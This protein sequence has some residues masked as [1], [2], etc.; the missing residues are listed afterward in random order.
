MNPIVRVEH[1]EKRF[2]RVAAIEGVSFE[3]PIG[4]TL[5]LLG[6]NGSGKTTLLRLLAGV[7]RPTRGTVRVFDAD[8]YRDPHR[9]ARRMGISYENHFLSPWATARDYLRFAAKAQGLDNGAVHEAGHD[10]ELMDYWDRDM[11]T[12]S[13]GMSKR[14][15]LAQAWLGNPGLLLLDEP[16]STL[17][18]QGRSILADLLSARSAA[19]QT[20][21]VATHLAE[22]VTLP[23]HVACLLLG[24]LEAEG[25]VSEL[26]V[27][28]GARSVA[29]ALPDPPEGVRALLEAGISSVTAT[30]DRVIVKGDQDT[31]GR[32]GEILRG[33][34][35]SAEPVEETFD[36]W[37]IYRSVLEGHDR[38]DL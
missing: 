32:A 13:A 6:P 34:G 33:M 8:P 28:Y 24:H 35:A 30:R 20:T 25:T 37:A 16:F 31:V 38:S 7:L 18:P 5:F 17:D 21:L 23:T 10:W 26:A 9:L 15:A 19:A 11:G 29:F 22:Q 12:Y 4:A 3:V 14:V 1:L 36:I 27:R 2:R